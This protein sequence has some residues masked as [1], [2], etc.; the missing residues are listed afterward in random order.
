V[1]G[2]V[3]DLLSVAKVADLAG[4]SRQTVYNWI[5]SGKLK[6]IG[7]GHFQKVSQEE[8]DGFLASYKPVVRDR[9]VPRGG[10]GLTCSGGVPRARFA[11]LELVRGQPCPEP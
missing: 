6:T 8:L 4:V 2:E 9:G 3:N 5:K 11:E 10:D 1:E 7:L